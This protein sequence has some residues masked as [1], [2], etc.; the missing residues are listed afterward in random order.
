MFALIS[1]LMLRTSLTWP[2]KAVKGHQTE[3]SG[4]DVK[5]LGSLQSSHKSLVSPVRIQ[6]CFMGGPALGPCGYLPT[7]YTACVQIHFTSRVD[8]LREKKYSN[9]LKNL[10]NGMWSPRRF[11]FLGRFSYSEMS[12]HLQNTWFPLS[13]IW[14]ISIYG[15]KLPHSLNMYYF[16]SFYSQIFSCNKN[17][18][19]GLQGIN[20]TF[21]VIGEKNS[22]DIFPTFTT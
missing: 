13:S 14:F 5:G 9:Q 1:L 20:E 11:F 18:K 4:A 19:I 22:M 7:T 3:P 12:G 8:E 17:I 15:I 2:P 6:R 21:L 10:G 16:T